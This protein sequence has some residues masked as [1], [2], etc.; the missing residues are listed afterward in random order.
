MCTLPLYDSAAFGQ[1][2]IIPFAILPA[3]SNK[4]DRRFR[5]LILN[6]IKEMKPLQF[7]LFTLVFVIL[8]CEAESSAK[9]SASEGS[10]LKTQSDMQS[11]NAG[12]LS[13]AKSYTSK[14]FSRGKLEQDLKNK[15]NSFCR[16]R[17]CLSMKTTVYFKDRSNKPLVVTTKNYST[18]GMTF[19]RGEKTSSSSINYNVQRWKK[20]KR[21]GSQ[22]KAKMTLS[23]PIIERIE[24]ESLMEFKK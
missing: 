1:I 15:A 14:N 18:S 5:Q 20:G 3:M 13:K 19:L 11:Y 12:I 24:T 8:S 23:N 21:E 2:V 17:T 7:L 16:T 10:A 4:R 6:K 9:V 22:T